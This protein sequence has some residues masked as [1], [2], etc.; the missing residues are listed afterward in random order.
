MHQPAQRAILTTHGSGNGLCSAPCCPQVIPKLCAM[1]PRTAGRCYDLCRVI[2]PIGR[3]GDINTHMQGSATHQYVRR[4]DPWS[5]GDNR[6]ATASCRPSW[7]RCPPTGVGAFM[8]HETPNR[9]RRAPRRPTASGW[10]PSV[11]E[12]HAGPCE[13]LSSA[14]VAPRATAAAPPCRQRRP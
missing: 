3:I 1:Q 9:R 7:P 4:N 12:A 8:P 2:H 14:R 13:A 6:P 11:W 5:G 10:C